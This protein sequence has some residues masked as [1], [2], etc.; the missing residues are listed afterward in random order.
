[1]GSF[2]PY[3]PGHLAGVRAAH[4]R[5]LMGSVRWSEFGSSVSGCG[6]K[7]MDVGISELTQRLA[8]D[9]ADC[10]EFHRNPIARPP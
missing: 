5:E 10:K 9:P 2:G 7:Y 1:M 3:H 6:W 8:D 4:H